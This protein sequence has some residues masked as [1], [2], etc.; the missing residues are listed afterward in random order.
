MVFPFKSAVLTWRWRRVA[1]CFIIP[2][3]DRRL[4]LSRQLVT[5]IQKVRGACRGGGA[6]FV[7]GSSSSLSSPSELR[8]IL[9]STAIRQLWRVVYGLT[10]GWRIEASV[11]RAESRHRR[12]GAP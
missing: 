9:L 3:E 7:F 8:R 4:A 12:E 6:S 2:P 5:Q 10:G 1:L 11:G